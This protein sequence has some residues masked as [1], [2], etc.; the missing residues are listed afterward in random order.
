VDYL[1][2]SEA[3]EDGV[4]EQLNMFGMSTG[5]AERVAKGGRLPLAPQGYT[6]RPVFGTMGPDRR[7]KKNRATSVR[8]TLR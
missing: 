4:Y 1:P 2:G 8:R 6:W 3:P 7:E 5:I